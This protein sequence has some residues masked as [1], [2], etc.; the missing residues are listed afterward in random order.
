M[1]GVVVGVCVSGGVVQ[2]VLGGLNDDCKWVSGMV[3]GMQV[4]VVG[5]R[6]YGCGF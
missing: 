4:V 6:N 2:L 3:A 1:A 5:V